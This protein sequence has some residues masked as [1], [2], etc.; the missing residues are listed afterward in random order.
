MLA[1]IFIIANLF[2]AA[3]YGFIGA[4]IAPKFALPKDISRRAKDAR[5]MVYARH[6][7]LLF[8]LMCAIDHLHRAGHAYW[9][10]SPYLLS[11]HMVIVDVVQAI[12]GWAFY[13]FA[14]ESLLIYIGPKD[15]G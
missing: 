8:F 4:L 3:A 12:A 15:Q 2:V 5:R 11:W 7:A 14:R 9:N 1:A 10:P 13:Y 6:A